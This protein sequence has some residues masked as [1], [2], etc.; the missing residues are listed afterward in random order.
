MY[1]PS[2]ILFWKTN[3]PFLC[4]KSNRHIHI[5]IHIH[6]QSQH[7]NRINARQWTP[8][9]MHIIFT[10]EAF[11]SS[12]RIKLAVAIE[13]QNKIDRKISYCN[14]Q[15]TFSSSKTHLRMLRMQMHNY[16]NSSKFYIL[17]SELI[18]IIIDFATTRWFYFHLI[19][20]MQWKQN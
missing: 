15:I 19:D 5:H 6:T 12:R 4:M 16:E 2:A 7:S 8:E 1:D 20:A 10:D 9:R 18:V 11:T 13:S 14:C 17:K 3:T